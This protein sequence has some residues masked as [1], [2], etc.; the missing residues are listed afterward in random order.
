MSAFNIIKSD[1]LQDGHRVIEKFKLDLP[2]S[3]AQ[4]GA[5]HQ[6]GN[7]SQKE[8]LN[9]RAT[10]DYFREIFDHTVSTMQ[11]E[12][13]KVA[14]GYEVEKE[15]IRFVITVP[16]Q[17][18]D[19]QRAIMRNV[20][21]EAGLITEDDHENRLLVINES[22]AATLHCEREKVN[23]NNSSR[24]MIEPTDKDTTDEAN[25]KGFMMK[26]DKYMICDAGGGTVDIAV[27]ESTGD[28]DD[29]NNDS[30]RR[31][32]LTADSGKKCG[33]VFLDQRMESLLLYICFGMK[34]KS[35]DT[36]ETGKKSEDEEEIETERKRLKSLI[37][38][39]I[40]IFLTLKVKF[41]SI[42]EKK[43]FFN[44]IL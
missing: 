9:M 35:D 27:F 43:K 1:Q 18:N 34:Q 3:I 4:K 6:T 22:L 13:V 15:N 39:L 41:H 42:F 21:K 8:L 20:A 26:N 30:F 2:S 28:G 16:A 33:S 7:T 23:V 19:V 29:S 14:N 10:I 31:C 11:K 44:L 37:A 40:E 24:N 32:Q 36:N 38:P 5:I 12:S 25:K 17:W